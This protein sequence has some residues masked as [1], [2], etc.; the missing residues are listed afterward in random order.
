VKLQRLA[1]LGAAATA[2]CLAACEPAATEVAETEQPTIATTPALA[3]GGTTVTWSVIQVDQAV[4]TPE[5]IATEDRT[6]TV[7]RAQVL[8]DRARFS[9]G[10]IDGKM[11]ENVRQAVAAFEEASGLAVDGQIDEAVFAKLTELD[12]R[13]V[14]TPYTIT[15]AD[16]AGPFIDAVPKD[17]EEQ[18]KLKSLRYTSSAEALG[19][20][21][22][23][24]E[25]LLK[26][27]NPTA[28]L[29]KAGT[30]I[31][32]ADLG[33]EGLPGQVARIEVDKAEKA[34]K[35]YDASNKL[36]AFYPAT[37]G[38]DE[39]ASPDGALKVRAV[40]KEP[41]YTWDPAKMTK[42][43][44]DH[45]LTIA[46]GPNNPVGAVWIALDKPTYGIH[47]APEPHLIGKR[48]SSGCVR[49][50]NWDA[51]ELASA[52]KAGVRVQ[53]TGSTAAPAAV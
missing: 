5:A 38:S 1:L 31:V 10:V 11:G 24:T 15:E 32:V 18:A 22:H 13:P 6:P 17:Y 50:T 29:T 2:L 42:K 36:L 26:T 49:L 12:A 39:L 43:G 51:Q 52:V 21:F 44:P 40:S 16:V 47:G 8:L 19:E 20:K 45:K 41:T 30:S 23:M 9:P 27:L 48:S 35:A 4:F 25:E 34:V 53:F 46:A 3:P 14:L 33:A 7:L 28:D 37:I